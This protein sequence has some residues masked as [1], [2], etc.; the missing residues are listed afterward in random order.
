M[1]DELNGMKIAIL[2]ADSVEQVELEKPREAV[3]EAGAQTEL[4]SIQEGE[5]Q[6]MNH[7]IDKA[8]KFPVDKLVAMSRRATT[9]G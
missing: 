1:A 9:T 3:T 2:A 7:D 6:A 8:D 4:L 5:I